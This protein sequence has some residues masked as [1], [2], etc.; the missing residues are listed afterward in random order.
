M[1]AVPA[2]S[3]HFELKLHTL[4]AEKRALKYSSGGLFMPRR[5]LV[6]ID[7]ELLRSHL[8][9]AD[10]EEK[11][12]EQIVQFLVD[13]GFEL[14]P[15]GWVV[16]EADLGVLDPEEVSRIDELPDTSS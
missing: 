14:T 10:R 7:V 16:S 5:F 9:E 2:N 1:D 15:R 12:T 6:Q 13:S 3:Y 4:S 11:S 8:S